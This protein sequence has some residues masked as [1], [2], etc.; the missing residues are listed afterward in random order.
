MAPAG[1]T[2]DGQTS[3]HSKAAWQR[4]T[5][6][7]PGRSNPPGRSGERPQDSQAAASAASRVLDRFLQSGRR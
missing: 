3:V 6:F 1:S 5:P 7:I 2:F 4:H